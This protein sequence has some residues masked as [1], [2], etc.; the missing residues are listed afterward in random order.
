MIDSTYEDGRTIIRVHEE[1]IEESVDPK[2]SK[3]Y[4]SVDEFCQYIKSPEELSRWLFFNKVNW[5][6]ESQVRSIERKKHFKRTEDDSPMVIWPEDILKY[7]IAICFDYA[8]FA[9]LCCKRYGLNSGILLIGVN[10][11]TRLF[12]NKRDMVGHAVC[13]YEKSDG[14]YILNYRFNLGSIMGPYNSIKDA[15]IDYCSTFKNMVSDYFAKYDYDISNSIYSYISDPK[16]LK[17]IEDNENK[18]ISQIELLKDV[19]SFIKW[20]KAYKRNISNQRFAPY[21]IIDTIR[22]TVKFD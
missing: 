14:Y 4:H 17:I 19:K 22:D 11:N 5:P 16:E 13:I 18:V 1:Y 7:K 21:D 12:S 8:I 6:T 15:V 3:Q 20:I 2:Y 9:N 10:V